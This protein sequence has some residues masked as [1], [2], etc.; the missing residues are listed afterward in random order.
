MFSQVSNVKLCLKERLKHA[1]Y[2]SNIQPAEY[3]ITALVYTTHSKFMIL[4]IQI[5][6]NTI[7]L[8]EN[9]SVTAS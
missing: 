5:K 8:L 7:Y 1:S 9:E 4:N 6:Q 3:C 2:I